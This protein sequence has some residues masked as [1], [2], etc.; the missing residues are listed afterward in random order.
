MGLLATAKPAATTETLLY[1]CPTE[2]EAV[3]NL[4]VSN[5]GSS[6]SVVTVSPSTQSTA[7]SSSESI[8]R[9]VGAGDLLEI[10]AISLSAGQKIFIQS[11]TGDVT[12]NCWGLEEIA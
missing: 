6:E 10:T 2:R 11:S 9:A 7:P 12:F 1:T 5:N 3:V 4:M 8:V